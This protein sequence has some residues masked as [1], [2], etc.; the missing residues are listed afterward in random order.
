LGPSTIIY[1]FDK[2]S[3][4]Y[5]VPPRGAELLGDYA[6]KQGADASSA[7]PS[8]HSAH[9]ADLKRLLELWPTL[10]D[11]SKA[12]ILAVAEQRM[13]PVVQT[14]DGAESGD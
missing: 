5:R 13:I 12:I 3:A 11:D 14:A 2:N 10:S 8:A 4:G 1:T 9:D 7:Q 6:G